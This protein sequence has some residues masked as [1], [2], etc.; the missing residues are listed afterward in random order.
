MFNRNFLVLLWFTM[1]FI[2]CFRVLSQIESRW[3]KI[4]GFSTKIVPYSRHQKINL[5]TRIQISSPV[6]HPLETFC[7]LEM[8]PMIT[9][10]TI[11]PIRSPNPSH[12]Q[13]PP[14]N[15]FWT[16]WMCRILPIS[17]KLSS[18]PKNGTLGTSLSRPWVERCGLSLWLSQLESLWACCVG[19]CGSAYWN[20]PWKV[21]ERPSDW[22]DLTVVAPSLVR[23]PYE[24]ALNRGISPWLCSIIRQCWKDQRRV[25]LDPRIRRSLW[26][27]ITWRWPWI[28]W[29]ERSGIDK[30]IRR[31]V[32]VRRLKRAKA[33]RQCC[34]PLLKVIIRVRVHHLWYLF[35][36]WFI[37]RI[38]MNP[39]ILLVVIMWPSS[40]KCCLF[41]FTLPRISK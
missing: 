39:L 7:H 38:R 15:V 16:M 13:H 11:T 8:Y 19:S 1:G 18:N 3:L 36:L 14:I 32:E 17:Q 12:H 27:S 5:P 25:D 24:I 29:F 10:I 33:P 41:S 37:V 6:P 21:D 35:S 26:P 31:E 28:T 30:R 2:I 40:R 4:G 23:K 9:S 34:Y 20:Y 22:S